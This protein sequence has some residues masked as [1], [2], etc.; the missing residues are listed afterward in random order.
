MHMCVSMHVIASVD[1]AK[2]AD[3]DQR[4]ASGVRTFDPL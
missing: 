2:H 4:T 1:M 3:G